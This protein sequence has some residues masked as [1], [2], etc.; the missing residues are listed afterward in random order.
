[1]LIFSSES[2]AILES[3]SMPSE[4]NTSSVTEIIS[5][6]FLQFAHFFVTSSGPKYQEI[7][8]PYQLRLSTNPQICLDPFT[9]LSSPNP[10][11]AQLI[12]IKAIY[13]G[14][15]PIARGNNKPTTGAISLKANSSIPPIRRSIVVSLDFCVYPIPKDIKNNTIDGMPTKGPRC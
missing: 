15:C 1:M 12:A 14:V 11:I 4:S 13:K 8:I 3:H 5:G 7:I 2:L 10:I 9:A 6:L